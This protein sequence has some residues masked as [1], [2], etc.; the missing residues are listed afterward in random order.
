MADPVATTPAPVVEGE[1]TGGEPKVEPKVEPTWRDTLPEKIRGE[2]TLSKFKD[3]AA[4]A[5]S[6]V[7][8]EKY[9][10]GAVRIPGESA[11]KD[12]I[13]AFNEKLGVP[14]DIGGYGLKYEDLKV[15]DSIKGKFDEDAF[16][17]F[18]TWAHSE[19]FTK[20][21]VQKM[22]DRFVQTQQRDDDAVAQAGARSADEAL[23]EIKKEWGSTT[24]RN[25]ALV[26][27]GVKEFFGPEFASWLEETG[28]G[29]DP[30]FLKGAL[31]TFQ[32]MMEDG[33]ISG[34]N[35]GTSRADAEAE[36]KKLQAS[37]EYKS[38]DRNVR[39]PVIERIRAL[40]EIAYSE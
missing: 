3:P 33:L 1:P 23:V 10:G 30:R 28:A 21:Q 18:L 11:T 14:K 24:G 22:V 19:G 17:N 6:Y 37:D 26:Q 7:N 29:N 4:L 35:L 34:E 16:G 36:I 38:K 8:L 31:R 40:S 12:E 9:A 25:L 5:E 32:P 13:A 20:K 15:P 27:R 39:L 2:K